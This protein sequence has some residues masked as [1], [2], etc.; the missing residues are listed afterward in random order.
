MPTVRP[1]DAEDVLVLVER[2]PEKGAA[3]SS[4]HV[5]RFAWQQQGHITYLG[6]WEGNVPLGHVYIRWPGSP[7]VSEPGGRLGNPEIADLWV[8]ENARRRGVGRQLL[9]TAE[10]LVR[11]RGHARVGLEVTLHNPYQAAARHLYSRAG[12]HDAGMAPFTSG[13]TYWDAAGVAHRDEDVYCY[14]LKQLDGGVRE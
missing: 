4:R 14:L 6:A 12:Y 5:D 8:A 9:E 10:E 13:Y 7:D 1:V 11:G 2:F 3:P